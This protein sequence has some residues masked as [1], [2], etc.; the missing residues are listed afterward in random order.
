MAGVIQIHTPNLSADLSRRQQQRS[1]PAGN[2]LL[3]LKRQI[4]RKSSSS[5]K[6]LRNFLID[7]FPGNCRYFD[8]ALPQT[9]NVRLIFSNSC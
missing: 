7:Q 5:A 2:K 3:I 1:E 6:F 4:W 8:D 9:P